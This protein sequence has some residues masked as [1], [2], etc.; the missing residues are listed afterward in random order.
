[1]PLY[2]AEPAAG[3]RRRRHVR[4]PAGA[5]AGG[6]RRPVRRRHVGR[7]PAEGVVDVRPV[8]HARHVQGGDLRATSRGDQHRDGHCPL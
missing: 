4:H 5:S 8:H 7:G 6:R 3:R 1:M 2:P